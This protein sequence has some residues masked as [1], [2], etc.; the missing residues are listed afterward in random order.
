MAQ[1]PAAGTW[2]E[3]QGPGSEFARFL[4]VGAIN[5]VI[6]YA[7]YLLASPWLGYHLAYALAYAVGIVVAYLLNSRFVFRRALSVRTAVR[8]PVVYLAQYLTGALCLYALVHGM[9]LDS[10]WAGLL[11]I[12]LSTPVSFVLNRLVLSLRDSRSG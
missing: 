1:D 9:G 4:V 3:R 2:R 5:T 8:Y 11:A 10:R 7:V 12:G 6:G